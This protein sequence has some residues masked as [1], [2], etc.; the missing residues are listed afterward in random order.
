MAKISAI[1]ITYNEA[2]NITECLESLKWCDEIIVI[3]SASSDN[4]CEL[5]REFTNNITITGNLPYGEKRNIG[6]EKASFEWILWIDA[7]ERISPELKEEISALINGHNGLNP[8]HEAYL[9]NRRSF[10]I[11]KFIKHSGWYPDFTLRLFKR[12]AGIRF[13]SLLV[14]EKAVYNGSTGRLKHDILHYTD[15]DFEHY[16]NKLNNYTSLS[17]EELKA[18]GK[19]ASFFDIIF[20][21]AFAFFK[22]Y[23]LKLGILDGYTGLVLCSLSSVHVMTKYSKLYLMNKSKL[24]N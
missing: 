20:R 1:V 22:M 6:I 10:F 7:D 18:K 2:A 11:N 24:N 9:V 13:D 14:H 19:K 3:D 5:A 17:A 12:S 4:T 15:R 8:K 23:F 21:P 16:I